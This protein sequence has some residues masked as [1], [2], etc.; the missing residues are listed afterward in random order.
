MGLQLYTYR[1]Y[2]VLYLALYSTATVLTTV[3]DYRA[4]QLSYTDHRPWYTG[5]SDAVCGFWS[6]GKTP[7]N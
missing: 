5:T 6:K 7:K 4:V 2:S 3:S 1:A